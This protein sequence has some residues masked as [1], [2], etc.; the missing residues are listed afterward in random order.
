MLAWRK[1]TIANLRDSVPVA[2]RCRRWSSAAASSR[3]GFRVWIS[4]RVL[5]ALRVRR[6]ARSCRS[7]GAARGCGRANT[8]TD[9]LTALIG[10]VSR[11][12]RRYGGYIV[13][14]GIVLI[15]LGFAGEGFKQDK[16]ILM[17]VGDETTLGRYTIRHD[18]LS[19]ADDGQKQMVTGHLAVFADGKQIDYA[20]PG[21]VVVPQ[22]RN[23]TADDRSGDSPNVR[24]GPVHRAGRLRCARPSR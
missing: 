18:R 9:F 11:N 23:G 13:H 24:G 7:S 12:K 15:F 16:Q 14:L 5:R 6:A 22:A 17:K 1:S 4:G 2:G 10:L 3:L 20:L 8:G 19:V 21:E